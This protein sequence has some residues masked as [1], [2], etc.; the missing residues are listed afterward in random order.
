MRE[1]EHATKAGI[2]PGEDVR[3]SSAPGGEAALWSSWFLLLLSICVSLLLSVLMHNV[4]RP[5]V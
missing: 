2:R 4:H 5:A 3:T 1:G